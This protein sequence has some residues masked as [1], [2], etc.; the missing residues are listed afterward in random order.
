MPRVVQ[1]WEVDWTASHLNRLYT[2]GT[3]MLP[4]AGLIFVKTGDKEITLNVAM[5]FMAAMA[6]MILENGKPM[7]PEKLQEVQK[8][9][10]YNVAAR[11]RHGGFTVK[12]KIDFIPETEQT[13]TEPKQ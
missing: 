12:S 8:E 1:K 10:F 7:T 5:P 6:Q 3:W 4:R 9:E 11:A 13:E 2:G